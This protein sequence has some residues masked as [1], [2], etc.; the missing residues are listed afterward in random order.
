MKKRNEQTDELEEWEEGGYEKPLW[1][2]YEKTPEPL[3]NAECGS[4]SEEKIVT[5]NEHEQT[6]TGS[7]PPALA[8]GVDSESV[9]SM[10]SEI[11]ETTNEHEQTRNDPDPA[12]PHSAIRDPQLDFIP[13][14]QIFR[15][16]VY[17]LEKAVNA[18]DRTIYVE[19]W[20]ENTG[21]PKIWYEFNKQDVLVK[22]TR[23]PSGILVTYLGKTHYL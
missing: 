15:R 21:R 18:Y 1:L 10:I 5:T 13:L 16:S 8:G 7:E 4:R 23:G 2:D 17:D 9:Q 20:E 19:E 11:R 14:D 12:N 22:S 6:R 3:R